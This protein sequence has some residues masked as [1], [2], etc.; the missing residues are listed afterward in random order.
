MLYARPTLSWVKS[1][2]FC[3]LNPHRVTQKNS[4]VHSPP[5]STTLHTHFYHLAGCYRVKSCEIPM[6]SA[7][8]HFPS[9][10]SASRDPSTCTRPVHRPPRS[11]GHAPP[12]PEG[13]GRPGRRGIDH[14][15]T[16]GRR[17][18]PTSA[19]MQ[20]RWISATQKDGE[21]SMGENVGY[22]LIVSI[23][24]NIYIYM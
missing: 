17:A 14:A 13:A 12:M 18:V 23:T 11:G 1:P 24:N 5:F 8:S 22:N 16:M 3:W 15:T 21:N 9:P 20:N 19:V 6:V 4:K 10:R 2:I 7:K